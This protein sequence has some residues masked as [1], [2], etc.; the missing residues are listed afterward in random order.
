M[1]N[2]SD[3]TSVVGV[4]IGFEMK[5][6]I[7]KNKSQQNPEVDR[8]EYLANQ[9]ESLVKSQNE[10]KKGRTRTSI[11]SLEDLKNEA[12]II[13][14]KWMITVMSSSLEFF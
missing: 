4:T 9:L 13:R 11:A 10:F 6:L 2:K 7:F 8:L 12:N 14:V 1:N 5:T 3:N